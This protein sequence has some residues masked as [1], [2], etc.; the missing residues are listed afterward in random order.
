[1]IA[2]HLLGLCSLFYTLIFKAT[3]LSEFLPFSESADS[4]L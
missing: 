2:N 1:M 4:H 3:D